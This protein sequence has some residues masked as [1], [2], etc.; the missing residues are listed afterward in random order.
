M[1]R[2]PTPQLGVSFPIFST[3]FLS[4]GRRARSTLDPIVG[5]SAS[6]LQFEWV[7]KTESG[8]IRPS[9][10]GQ[11]TN[12]RVQTD[13]AI[14]VSPRKNK[15]FYPPTASL[16]LL[17]ST[18]KFSPGNYWKTPPEESKKDG[19]TNER[20]R[21]WPGDGQTKLSEAKRNGERTSFSV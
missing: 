18:R 3:S 20:E 4:L 6:S 13:V 19:R 7:I 12:E 8:Q 17:T 14:D 21:D 5:I 9:S 1:R 16:F 15:T 11:V 10:H 2:L